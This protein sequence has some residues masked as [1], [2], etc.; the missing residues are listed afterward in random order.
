MLKKKIS[1]IK[2][3]IFDSSDGNVIQLTM[4][5]VKKKFNQALDLFIKW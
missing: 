2:K 5:L 3:L 4:E 1:Q